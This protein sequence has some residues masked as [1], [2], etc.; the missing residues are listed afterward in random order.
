M[1]LLSSP[2]RVLVCGA[3]SIGRRH[4]ANLLKLGADVSVW[5]AREDLLAELSQEFP[6]KTFAKLTTAI[7]QAE[8]VVVATAT[9]EH[10]IIAKEVLEARRALFIEKPISNNWEGIDTLRYLVRD[11]V[12]EIGCQFRAHPNLKALFSILNMSKYGRP[13]TY[14]LVMG[15]RLDAWRATQDY[16]QGYSANSTRGGGALFDL[17]H[18]IDIA[19][20]HF[21]PII[22]VNAVLGKIGD[23]NIQG[24]D[25]ANLILTHK[26]GVTGQI[27]LD[28]V[29]PVHRCEAEII[30]SEARITWSNTEGL[31]RCQLPDSE[32]IADRIPEEFERND[33]FLTHMAHFLRRVDG[34]KLTPLCSF[35]E[36]VAALTVALS[37]RESN[38]SG[39][40]VKIQENNLW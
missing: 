19:L 18:Q 16:Q 37:A 15:H 10:V 12:V 35:E 6:V 23:L 1:V 21:G 26:S 24:D 4:I 31:L 11:A 32:I 34:M 29:S 14:R 9:D 22:A 5:R 33:L 38:E 40:M 7:A 2:K 39:K 17:I 25:I 30:T 27:Q 36:G 28:M 13:L 20:W 3:G 8:A